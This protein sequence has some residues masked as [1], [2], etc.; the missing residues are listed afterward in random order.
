MTR[1]EIAQIIAGIG[2]PYAYDHF[3][4]EDGQHPQGP[5]FIC[6]LYPYRADLMADNV[7]YAPIT[8]LTVELYTDEVD[9]ALEDRTEAALAAAG[10]TYGKSGPTYI[11]SEKMYLT[12]YNTEVLINAQE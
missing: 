10:L 2:L 8:A 5:P 1:R 9:F 12:T 4:S 6:F 3:E 7:N 11:D